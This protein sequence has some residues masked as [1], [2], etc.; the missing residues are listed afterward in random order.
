MMMILE[1]IIL[2]CRNIILMSKENKNWD[3]ECI[4]KW[5]CV[6]DKVVFW[7]VKW[8]EIA[9]SNIKIYPISIHICGAIFLPIWYNKMLLYLFYLL[10]LQN[11]QY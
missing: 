5:Y 6:I 1:Y 9:P 7:M 8:D 3:V 2:L 4:V 11:I 10:T